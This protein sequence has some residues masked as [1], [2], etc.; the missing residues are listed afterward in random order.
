MRTFLKMKRLSAIAIL[1]TIGHWASAQPASPRIYVEPQD[2]FESYLS[3][4]IVKK[5]VPA[6]VTQ[7]KENASFVLTSVVLAKEESTGSKVARCL[8]AY[9]AG[10]QGTQTATVQL[11]NVRTKEVSWG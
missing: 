1:L 2:G 9:C 11:I 8:F 10:I 7:D 5:H 4:A 3:A 6:V